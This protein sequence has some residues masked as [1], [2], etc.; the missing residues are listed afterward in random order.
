MDVPQVNGY[1]LFALKIF[2][3]EYARL[4]ALV[5]DIVTK[6]DALFADEKFDE[7]ERLLSHP[8]IKLFEAVDTLISEKVPADPNAKPYRLGSYL[9][10]NYS[11]WRRIKKMSL[12]DRYRLFF[13][14][15]S[16]PPK[17]IVYA[18]LNDESTL[19][20][21]GSKTDPYKVFVKMLKGGKVPNEWSELLDE[22]DALALIDEEKDG[23]SE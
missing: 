18:W 20:K 9:G 10:K 1:G 8:T 23:T 6:A 16:T 13:R 17:S 3:Q 19:R 15:S 21:S 11:S 2:N 12:P 22:A 5:G 4:Q 7:A 14:F